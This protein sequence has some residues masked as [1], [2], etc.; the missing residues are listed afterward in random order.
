MRERTCSRLERCCTRWRRPRCP[1]TARLPG[2][3]SK[4]SLT[5]IRRRPFASTATSRPSWKTSSIRPWRKIANASQAVADLEPAAP[6]ELGEAVAFINNLYPAY[7]RGQAYLLAHNGTAAAA[8]FQKLLDHRGIVVNFV[9]G[10]LASSNRP[11][12]CDGRW[13]GES[14]SRVP[15]L[16]HFMERRRPRHPY[17]EAS[18]S[19]VGEAAIAVLRGEVRVSRTWSTGQQSP[20]SN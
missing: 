11:R 4:P 19:R 13:Y 10:S 6:Y 2:S 15:G 3:S 18:Q 8:Q 20:T 9:T 5:P 14:K 7:V 12:L 16:L 1:F 17:P